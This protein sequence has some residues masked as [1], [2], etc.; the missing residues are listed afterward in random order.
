MAARNVGVNSTFEQQRQVINQIASDVYTIQNTGIFSEQ[1]PVFLSSA[2]AGIGSSDI[3]NWNT[4]YS[5]GDH[6]LVGYATE[7]YVDSSIVGYATEGYVDSSIVGFITS[8]SLSG[9][10]T[11]AYVNQQINSL[12]DG[13]PG[14]LDTL[15][16]LSAALND[17]ANFATTITNSLSTK[18][19]GVGIESGGVL[20]GSGI[21][22]LNFIGLGN[23]LTVNGS[24]VDISISGTDGNSGQFEITSTGIHTLSN[25]GIGT[26]NPTSTLTVS[27]DGKFTGVVTATKFESSIAGTPT[28]DSP[29]NLNINAVTVA[30]STDLSVGGDVQVLGTISGDGSQI[31]NIKI[32]WTKI[33]L[34]TQPEIKPPSSTIAN[35]NYL[36]LNWGDWYSCT[37]LNAVNTNNLSPSSSQFD[38]TLS[39]VGFSTDRFNG[40]SQGSTYEFNIEVEVYDG[41]GRSPEVEQYGFEASTGAFSNTSIWYPGNGV[42]TRSLIFHHTAVFTFEDPDPV[43][44]WIKYR[45]HSSMNSTYYIGYAILNIK[46]IA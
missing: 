10:A 44:N 19:S 26:T 31:T 39:G 14:A 25:V 36:G 45:L 38:P 24:R 16:E 29:N 13:A 3:N 5:W 17:D 22:T 1:D 32:P 7:G 4:S 27:G 18:I 9:Y 12:V 6:A 21:T 43:N 35:S 20:V 33:Y 34:N 46:K 41:S 37:F 30:I 42:G 15:N 8:G 11:E 23:T 40:F 2:A 28:I